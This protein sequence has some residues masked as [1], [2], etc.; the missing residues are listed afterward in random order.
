MLMWSF[1]FPHK[2]TFSS[3]EQT[4]IW[5]Y[6]SNLWLPDIK[7]IE[8]PKTVF[9]IKGVFVWR[10]MLQKGVGNNSGTSPCNV[11]A[12]PDAVEKACF[13]LNFPCR[14]GS[15]F[16]STQVGNGCRV[17]SS[18]ALCKRTSSLLVFQLALGIL[19]YV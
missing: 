2:M 5:I 12:V 18:A 6:V 10:R 1:Q 19:H 3:F 8:A 9:G 14:T 16:P 15:A 7:L 11:R 4:R 17:S 13:V